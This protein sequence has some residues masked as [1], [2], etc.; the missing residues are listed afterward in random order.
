MASQLSQS[1]LLPPPRCLGHSCSQWESL[2]DKHQ[3]ITS[4]LIILVGTRILGTLCSFEALGLCPRSP[5]CC[6]LLF[7][8][9]L[10]GGFCCWAL[11]RLV[12][13]FMRRIWF[14]VNSLIIC[15]IILFMRIIVS[16]VGLALFR[17]LGL[18]STLARGA[19]KGSTLE[20]KRFSSIRT[21]CSC[22]C[23]RVFGVLSLSMN[24]NFPSKAFVYMRRIAPSFGLKSSW[25]Y[26]S[27]FSNLVSNSFT[28]S[29]SFFFISLIYPLYSCT[30]F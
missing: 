19:W 29:F 12:I 24:Q 8:G 7:Y 11:S 6:R 23:T 16:Y 25:I 4:W 21:A 15:S 27:K 20:T 10:G 2:Q 28:D 5:L 14:C 26:L 22:A 17:V 13:L 3:G 18:V 1:S 9:G 30:P